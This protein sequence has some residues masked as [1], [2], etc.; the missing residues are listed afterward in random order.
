MSATRRRGPTRNIL[1]NG[2]LRVA[3]V[4]SPADS[5]PEA[6]VTRP[7]QNPMRLA[8]LP[9]E[10]RASFSFLFKRNETGNLG[11]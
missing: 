10:A 8:Y 11:E 4:T 6:M 3:D 7:A 2:R 1:A 5:L 9:N